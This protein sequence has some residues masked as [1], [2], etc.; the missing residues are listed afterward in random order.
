MLK[1]FIHS[2]LF[3][4]SFLGEMCDLFL[5]RHGQTIQ[6]KN[7]IIQGQ[8]DGTLTE[9]GRAQ[10]TEIGQLFK[11]VQFDRVYC[12][13]LGRTRETFE[14]I[15]REFDLPE[16][17]KPTVEYLKLLR[18]RSFGVY[19][20]RPCED[21]KQLRKKEELFSRTFRSEKGESD[22][23]VYKRALL[24]L[25]VIIE[26]YL[27]KKADG[28]ASEETKEETN[29]DGG[30]LSQTKKKGGTPT[31]A[32]SPLKKVMI[33]SHGGFLREF[34]YV[35]QNWNVEE[36]KKNFDFFSSAP[37]CSISTISVFCEK[38]GAACDEKCQNDSC[39]RFVL[40]EKHS[41]AHQKHK[42]Q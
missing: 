24:F 22:E 15:S 8:I 35:F 30:S 1:S 42:N 5:V 39:I 3:R 36:S 2:K 25:R 32:T 17:P 26:K 12:S 29:L 10:A 19:E 18:E 31:Q 40:K 4:K 27:K 21:Y 38:T 34:F 33:V 16:N 9:T 37:N 28:P 41:V 23:D 11:S 7:R 13:D 6:N 20:G 14:F